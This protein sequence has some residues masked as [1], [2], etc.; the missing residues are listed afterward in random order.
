MK[1][2]SVLLLIVLIMSLGACDKETIVEEQTFVLE[3]S[4]EQLEE[5]KAR[6]GG[7]CYYY[8]EFGRYVVNPF[9]GNFYCNKLLPGICRAEKICIPDFY[10]DPCW[11]VPCWIDFL[12]PWIIYE[13]IRPEE[14]GNIREK[15]ELDI[16]PEIGAVPFALNEEIAGL[17]YYAKNGLMEFEGNGE[18]GVF[19]LEEN[20][21]L[22]AEVS[23]GLGLRG[24][25]IKAGKYPVI[26]NQKNETFNV[27]LSV[28]K[29]FERK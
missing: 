17:Q 29:G 28:E 27:I 15:V 24:N 14:F 13:K 10:F 22:D 2:S 26:V 6:W 19:Y 8:F 23:K 16:N 7:N 18:G 20:L 3:E 25:V 12:D 4:T 1:K 11:L 21:T 5:S 9:T